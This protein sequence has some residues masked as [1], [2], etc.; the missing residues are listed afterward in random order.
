MA[1][2]SPTKNDSLDTTEDEAALLGALMGSPEQVPAASSRLGAKDLS[3]LAAGVIYDAILQ[4]H[5]AGRD[6]G[7]QNVAAH[8]GR[9]GLL[10]KVGG[11]EHL[12]HLRQ[13]RR[14]VRDA[15]GL[16]AGIRDKAMRRELV[17]I[18]RRLDER[19]RDIGRAAALTLDEA[20]YEL[21]LT[22]SSFQ[23]SDLPVAPVPLCDT[24][25][26]LTARPREGG[27]RRGVL[28]SGLAELDRLIGG[29]AKGNLTVLAA[30]PGMHADA[31]FTQ[32]MDAV[33]IEQGRPTLILAAGQSTDHV[34]RRL[35]LSH[36]RM[37]AEGGQELTHDQAEALSRV[38]KKLSQVR[39]SIQTRRW[40][41]FAEIYAVTLR[42][43]AGLDIECVF[44]DG[45][46]ALFERILQSRGSLAAEDLCDR[47]G[48]LSRRFEIPVIG[49]VEIDPPQSAQPGPRPSTR[50]LRLAEPRGIAGVADTVLILHNED[51]YHRGEEGYKP[52]GVTELAIIRHPCGCAGSIPLVFQP[53][54]N[55]FGVLGPEGG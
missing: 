42:A 27:S 53:E 43:R 39:I 9:S 2:G 48:E 40:Q 49:T 46:A 6:T 19:A 47:L 17:A 32:W 34:A 50:D 22:A 4:L 36:G 52:A 7:V 30:R 12:S 26:A 45:I 29:F 25:D 3:T 31:L 21:C 11:F 5:Q 41:T 10:E 18:G 20:D 13:H 16:A 35:V 8:L 33:A 14:D 23:G 44:I 37:F 38:R 51:H 24:A 1:D 55:R 28:A 15:G 54:Q